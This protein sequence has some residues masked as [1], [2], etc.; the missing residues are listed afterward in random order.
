MK[1]VKVEQLQREIPIWYA[2][3]ILKFRTMEIKKEKEK[4]EE[5]E[6]LK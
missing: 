3:I 4:K 2:L 6:I 5:R 1:T